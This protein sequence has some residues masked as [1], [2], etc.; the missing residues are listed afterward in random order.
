MRHSEWQRDGRRQPHLGEDYE[1]VGGERD[2]YE[3]EMEREMVG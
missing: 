3:M 2:G 1:S